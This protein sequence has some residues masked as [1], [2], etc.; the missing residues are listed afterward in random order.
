MPLYVP[1]RNV[2]LPNPA[3]VYDGLVTG[4]W[5]AATGSARLTQVDA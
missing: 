3:P 5:T 4:I 1:R 2:A